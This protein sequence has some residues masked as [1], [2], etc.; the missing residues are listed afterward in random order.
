MIRLHTTRDAELQSRAAAGGRPIHSMHQQMQ[1]VLNSISSET[2]SFF[3]IPSAD[4]ENGE[5]EWSAAIPGQVRAIDSLSAHE[6]ED[7]RDQVDRIVSEVER[8]ATELEARGD[9]PMAG[10]LRL[11]LELPGEDC[12]YSVGGRPVAAGWGHVRRG[13]AAPEHVLRTFLRTTPSDIS[14]PRPAPESSP[15][16]AEPAPADPKR[17]DGPL[18]GSE[19]TPMPER[20][21][22]GRT[23]W[24]W[25]FQDVPALSGAEEASTSYNWLR[26]LLFAIAALLVLAALWMAMRHCALGWPGT[27]GFQGVIWNACPGATASDNAQRQELEAKL[28]RLRRE[29][30]ARRASCPAIEPSRA[31]VVP[32]PETDRRLE[33]ENA[34][35]GATNVVLSWNGDDDLDLLVRCPDGEV[36]FHG[37]PQTCGGQ[38]DVDMNYQDARSP[39]PVENIVW[40]E[41]AAQPGEYV[42]GVK[43]ATDA[44]PIEPKT[45]FTIELRIGGEVV[46]RHQGDADNRETRV[47]SF[48][49]PYAGRP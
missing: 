26:W 43:R 34:R 45:S 30:D 21:A 8:H 7:L 44:A 13:D 27:S 23:S 40:D 31:E 29:L 11:A 25:T 28:D 38:L 16:D 9:N 48:E 1:V 41:G 46:E 10:A 39:D 18:Q 24:T 5:I 22:D 14:D 37:K 20:L 6:R 4:P 32:R 15:S 36:I 19:S 2:A 12:L 47:F 35:L 42:V 17:P 49:L 33:R 3:A